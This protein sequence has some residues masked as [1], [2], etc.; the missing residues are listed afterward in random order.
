LGLVLAAGVLAPLLVLILEVSG[1]PV[2]G[3]ERRARP[4]TAVLRDDAPDL[5]PRIERWRI[6]LA[7]GDTVRALWRRAPQNVVRPWT[8]VLMGGLHTGDRAALVL[9]D[10]TPAHALAVD[11]PWRGPRKMSVMRFVFSLPAI[12]EAL[13]RSPAAMASGLEAVARSAEVDTSR[14]VALGASLGAPVALAA[15]RV[16][17]DA[18]ALVLIDGGAGLDVCCG[19]KRPLPPVGGRGRAAGRGLVRPLGR[20]PRQVADAKPLIDARDEAFRRSPSGCT[21]RCRMPKCAGEKPSTSATSVGDD[22]GDGGGIVSWLDGV[23]ARASS[24]LTPPARRRSERERTYDGARP[25]PDPA[26]LGPACSGVRAHPG[27]S[28]APNPSRASR[29]R[30]IACAE[31]GFIAWIS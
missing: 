11:W 5:G 31:C 17:N 27:P 20:R 2:R 22:S 3:L 15:L 6:V 25:P 18:R 13:L 21:P 12:R 8:V 14:I 10:D 23:T 9:P 19:R 4:V 28:S 16:S 1:D 7:G 30:S 29:M 24:I 26:A